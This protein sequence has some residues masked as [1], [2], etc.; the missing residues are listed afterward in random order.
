MHYVNWT[1]RIYGEMTSEQ[2]FLNS[3][4]FLLFPERPWWDKHPK[5]F[6]EIEQVEDWDVLGGLYKEVALMKNGH[7]RLTKKEGERKTL[8]K[9]KMLDW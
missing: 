7:A 4:L 6:L 3:Q 5:D 8:C 1:G 2:Y 9:R